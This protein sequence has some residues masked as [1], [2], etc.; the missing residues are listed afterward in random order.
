VA[1]I[2]GLAF[3]AGGSYVSEWSERGYFGREWLR[4]A[5]WRFW[6]SSKR[7]IVKEEKRPLPKYFT[8]LWLSNE[9]TSLAERFDSCPP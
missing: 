3:V 4:L 5:C 7:Q 6:M 1:R 8:P 9:E 2:L